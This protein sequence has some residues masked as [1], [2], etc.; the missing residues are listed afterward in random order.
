MKAKHD[1][2]TEIEKF[3]IC[4]YLLYE[5]IDLAYQCS[6]PTSNANA[7]SLRVQAN[8]WFNTKPVK[9]YLEK[10]RAFAFGS[11]ADSKD[12]PDFTKK[13]TL[14]QELNNIVIHSKS[15][16]ERAET[17]KL[18]AQIL[19]MNK[20]TNENDAELVHFYLPM[21]CKRCS[22]YCSEIERKKKLQLET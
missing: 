13:G 14:L 17:L 5:N 1:N 11:P 10:E 9:D 16:K 12:A 18:I 20:D 3:A 2:L 8:R 6:H 4:G 15:G 7:V 21:T 22:L 19:Q